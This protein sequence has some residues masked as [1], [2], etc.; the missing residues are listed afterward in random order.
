MM[1]TRY[2]KRLNLRLHV[3]FYK[4]IVRVLLDLISYIAIAIA[5]AQ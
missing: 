1:G 5:R 2:Y 4:R 3:V